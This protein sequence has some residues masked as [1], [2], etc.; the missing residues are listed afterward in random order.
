MKERN[1]FQ[2]RAYFELLKFCAV[3]DFMHDGI[4]RLTDQFLL[5]NSMHPNNQ[6]ETRQTPFFPETPERR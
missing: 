1:T 5:P 2:N 4:Q 3:V 6:S